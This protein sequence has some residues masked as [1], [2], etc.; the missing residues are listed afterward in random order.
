MQILRT[1]LIPLSI[2]Q[3]QPAPH[4][5][6]NGVLVRASQAPGPIGRFHYN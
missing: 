3:G 5:G 1:L 4:G 6:G 2:A